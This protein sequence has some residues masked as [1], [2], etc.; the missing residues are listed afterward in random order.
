M[1]RLTLLCIVIV[2]GMVSVPALGQSLEFK[3]ELRGGEEVPPV[4]TAASGEVK[5]RVNGA[6]TE[7]AFEL[8]IKGATNILSAAGAHLHCGA[9]GVNGPVVAFLAGPVTGG[10]DGQVEIKA[11]LTD[12]NI[13]NP[14]C[15][16]T[17]AAL[18]Q[19]MQDGRVYA[20]AH[21]TAFPA[22]EIRGQV[23]PD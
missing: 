18:V 5:L 7:I 12:A 8:E 15:G 23:R 10:F 22:G 21:S 17:I 4:S 13:T 16:S 3:A 9:Q 6:R 20:N 14:A 2:L 1:S 11:V 19:S